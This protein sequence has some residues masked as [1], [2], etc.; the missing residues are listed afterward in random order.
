[1]KSKSPYNNLYSG[2][3]TLMIITLLGHGWQLNFLLRE[4]WEG[5]GITRTRE[6]VVEGRK[7]SL[8]G[9]RPLGKP[10]NFGFLTK[11]RIPLKAAAPLRPTDNLCVASKQQR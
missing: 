1:M 10:I 5:T 4:T 6:V 11:Q 7:H 3:N 2:P 8:T 9:H